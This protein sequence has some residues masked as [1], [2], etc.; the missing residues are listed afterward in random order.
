MAQMA[1]NGWKS[2]LLARIAGNC[3]V[4]LKWLD[5]GEMDENG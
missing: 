4:W 3:W 2:L 5:I 1:G